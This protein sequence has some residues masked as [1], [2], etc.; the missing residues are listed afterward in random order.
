MSDR[1]AKITDVGE[2]E[3]YEDFNEDAEIQVID[4]VVDNDEFQIDTD[5]PMPTVTRSRQSKYPWGKLEVGN[6]F[7]IK[8]RKPQSI[9]TTR[10]Y[11]QKKYNAQ[12]TAQLV[13][14]N[15]VQG[16][17]VWRIK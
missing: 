6:S 9:S 5:I 11:A 14:E 17:R 13:T 15:E 3:E 7:F 1:T 8:G 4:D 10:R 16:T 2:T 12:Y